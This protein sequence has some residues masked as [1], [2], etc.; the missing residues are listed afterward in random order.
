M[1]SEEIIIK[2]PEFGSPQNSRGG[3]ARRDYAHPL[4]SSLIKFLDDPAINSVFKQ[5]VAVQADSTFGSVLASGVAINDRNYPE[6]NKLVNEC[7]D[8]LNIHR[9]YVIISDYGPNLNAM[10]FGSDEE[11]YVVL[12][13]LMV[14]TMSPAQLKFIIGHECGHI[15]MGHMIY[16]TVVEVATNFASL[17]PVIG[18]VVRKVG[19]LPLMAWS[20]RSEISADRAGLLCCGDLETAQRTLMQLEIPF[21][22]ASQIDV[23]DYVTD[24][25]KYLRGGDIRKLGEF[26]SSHPILSKRIKALDVFGKSEKYCRLTSRSMTSSN[27]LPDSELD[28]ETEKIISVL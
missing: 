26:S 18:P 21:L 24:S 17:I 3:T 5:I 27:L 16:H 13:P 14:K 4:D 11:P 28:R 8:T 23:R 19:L 9:P 1:V 2:C 7:V 10:T 22:D 20:R 25:E 6:L 15:A 12:T